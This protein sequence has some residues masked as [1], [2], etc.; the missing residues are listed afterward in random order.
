MTHRIRTRSQQRQ[1]LRNVQ[2]HFQSIDDW[3]GL[4]Q[5]SDTPLL[6]KKALYELTG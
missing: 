1:R 2:I 5:K 3:Y 4:A 6:L